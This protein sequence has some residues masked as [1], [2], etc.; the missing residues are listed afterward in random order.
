MITICKRDGLLAV[1]YGFDT[2]TIKICRDER[3]RSRRLAIAG[4]LGKA[5]RWHDESRLKK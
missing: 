1:I 5:R 2:I 4:H 3:R